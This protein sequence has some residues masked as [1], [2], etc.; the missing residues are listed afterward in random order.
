MKFAIDSNTVYFLVLKM[1]SVLVDER[2]SKKCRTEK[3]LAKIRAVGHF[4]AKS[5]EICHPPQM[6]ELVIHDDQSCT[7][8]D[9]ESE[10]EDNTDNFW[11]TEVNPSE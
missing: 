2:P 1:F 7:T 11:I 8:S 6:I 10:P 3:D 4:E 9:S 5:L